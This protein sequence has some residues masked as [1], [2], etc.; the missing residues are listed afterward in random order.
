MSHEIKLQQMSVADLAQICAQETDLYFTHHDYDSSYCFE[1]F[2]RAIR[3]ND[4]YALEV[5]II[6]YQPLVARW[7]DR[8]MAKHPDFPLANAEAQDFIAQAFERFW[9]SFTPAKFDKSQSLAA[10]LRYLQM[11]VNG[12]ITDTWRKSRRIQLEQEPRDEEQELSEPESTPEELLQR[13]EFW[14]LIKKKSKDPKEYTVVY[15]S[16][17]LA[18]SPREILAEYPGLFSDIKEIYQLKANLLDRLERDEEM[19]D[20]SRR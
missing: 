1:L 14:Q 19:K 10:V 12:A 18:L 9:I 5:I 11:C 2:R 7:V 15:A 8:W 20:F 6:Q 16:F 13:D 3:N 4:E 17:S